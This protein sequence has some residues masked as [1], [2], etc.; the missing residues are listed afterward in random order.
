MVIN[1]SN[2]SN[3]NYAITL[4]GKM[5]K[6]TISMVYFNDTHSRK[7]VSQSYA[8]R[9][10]RR[11]FKVISTSSIFL[12]LAFTKGSKSFIFSPPPAAS[13]KMLSYKVRVIFKLSLEEKK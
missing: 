9:N 3:I 8:D 1:L 6:K 7:L 10:T 5:Y 4:R 13:S 12:L 11:N 2:L